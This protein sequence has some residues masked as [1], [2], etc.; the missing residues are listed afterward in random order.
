MITYHRT[1]TDEE[2]K[3]ILALQ[4]VNLSINISDEE[5]LKEG[6]VTLKHDLDILKKMNDACAHC[7]AKIDGKTIGFALSMLQSFKKDV[8]LLIPMFN[9]VDEILESEKLS[10]KYVVMG[11]VCIDKNQ[12]GKGVFKGL[13][14]YMAREMKDDYDSIITEVD[15]KN[16]RSLNAHKS[17]GFKLLKKY[18]SNNQLWE[19]IILDL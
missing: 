15:V 16:I 7:I 11:Q 14:A 3:E 17:V 1:T 4:Q 2:L 10:S 19:I 5:K 6:F 18:V 13:Y 12:R 9:R 8:P